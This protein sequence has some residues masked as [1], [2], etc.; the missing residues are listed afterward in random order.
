MIYCITVLLSFCRARH[1][2]P[3][4]DDLLSQTLVSFAGKAV[5]AA[6]AV[7]LAKVNR[8]ADAHPCAL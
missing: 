1:F 4:L 5:M 7:V 3:G 8:T 6:T 2:E